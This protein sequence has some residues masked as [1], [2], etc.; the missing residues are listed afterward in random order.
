MAHAV[1][2]LICFGEM[3]SGKTFKSGLLASELGYDRLEGDGAAPTAM[4]EAVRTFGRIHRWMVDELVSQLIEDI[5]DA[6]RDTRKKGI[7]VSQA[8]YFDADRLRIQR[9]LERRGH[10]NV[11]W[12]WSR[13]GFW[14]NVYQL[15]HRPDGFRWVSY[16]LRNKRFFE[17]PTHEHTVIGHRHVR[18]SP[19]KRRRWV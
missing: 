6:A 1:R 10:A 13:P 15:L 5:D 19:G 7:V 17:R 8:L 14:R 4:A 3:G 2:I 11:G 16:W 12:V 9:E 18:R